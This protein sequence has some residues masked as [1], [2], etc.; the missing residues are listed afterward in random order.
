MKYSHLTCVNTLLREVKITR[1][2][3]IAKFTF[4]LNAKVSSALGWPDIPDK[5]RGWTPED[6]VLKARLIELKP[7]NEDL[8][9]DLATAVECSGIGDFQI[10]R[11]EEKS[12]KDSVKSKERVTEVFC[13]VTLSDP[14]GSAKLERYMSAKR[15]EM[16]ITSLPQRDSENSPRSTF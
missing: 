10:I 7:N 3:V 16:R 1:K 9:A 13:S 6:S 2:A 12:G 5:T 4:P 15:S 14:T 11:K 8:F